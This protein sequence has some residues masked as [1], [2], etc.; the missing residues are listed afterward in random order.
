MSTKRIIMSD[1]R[2]D[3][4]A[5][6]PSSNESTVMYMMRNPKPSKVEEKDAKEPDAKAEE[7]ASEAVPSKAAR[8][9]AASEA[10]RPSA[11]APA[12]EA[13]Q[14]KAPYVS[15]MSLFISH[16]SNY[17]GDE[18]VIPADIEEMVTRNV[19][20]VVESLEIGDITRIDLKVGKNTKTGAQYIDAF[21]HLYWVDTPVAVHTQSEIFY[22]GKTVW[23]LK[24]AF[25]VVRKNANPMSQAE[26][27]LMKMLGVAIREMLAA[28]EELRTRVYWPELDQYIANLDTHVRKELDLSIPV[29]NMPYGPRYSF[30]WLKY[31]RCCELRERLRFHIKIGDSI[32]KM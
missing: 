4:M 8:A 28:Y 16:V 27:E 15:D 21:V 30:M 25:W 23:Y 32:A 10:L 31:T 13:V 11:A 17:R 19:A 3:S 2:P 9:A 22:Y 5:D 20:R 6:D 14:A 7:P 12:S 18:H 24:G 26:M 29:N 1:I